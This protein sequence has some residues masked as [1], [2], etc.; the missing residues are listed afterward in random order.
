M[1]VVDAQESSIEMNTR[2]EMLRNRAS[3]P[4]VEKMI[5]SEQERE[6]VCVHIA[7]A[8]LGA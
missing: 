6:D 3:A 4:T 1:A 8:E 5:V 2:F 7:V